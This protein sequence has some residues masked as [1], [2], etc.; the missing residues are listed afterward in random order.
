MLLSYLERYGYHYLGKHV[1]CATKMASRGK[2]YLFDGPV[3]RKFGKPTEWFRYRIWLYDDGFL[4]WYSLKNV[5]NMLIKA[6][7]YPNLDPPVYFE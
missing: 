4:L 7:V 1:I 5:K 6:N 3:N 2:F